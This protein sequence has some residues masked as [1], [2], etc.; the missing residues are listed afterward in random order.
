MPQ[1][2]RNA[3]RWL[4][5]ASAAAMLI[6][7]IS[8]AASAQ[9]PD[10][11]IITLCVARNGKIVGVDI[12]CK[13]HNL[14]LTWNIPGATGPAGPQGLTGPAGAPGS[15]GP[16]GTQG[17]VGI[18]G[19]TGPMGSVGLTGPDGEEGFIG[20][21]GPTGN[22]GHPGPTGPTGAPGL[23]GPSGTPSFPFPSNDNVEVLSGGTL[24][25][26]IGNQASIQLNDESGSGGIPTQPLYMGPGNGASGEGISNFPPAPVPGPQTSVEVPMPGGTAFNLTV[27]ITPTGSGPVGTAYNFIICNGS[28]SGTSEPGDCDFTS[29]PFPF[30]NSPSCFIAHSIPTPEP[31]ICNSNSGSILSLHFNPGDPLSIMA[32]S[33]EANPTSVVNVNWSMDFAI[34]TAAA[35]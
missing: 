30:D 29:N 23:V 17:L 31:Q 27:S 24:G 25:G 18:V 15:V 7:C 21:T 3:W 12:H 11:G 33:S 20:P 5:G 14:Q 32:Y 34:D 6:A 22:T 10:T 19:P 2:F 13:P 1:S 28:L 9:T 4:L 35:F 16:T 26:T 8:P